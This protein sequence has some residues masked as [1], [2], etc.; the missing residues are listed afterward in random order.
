MF[1]L[2]CIF[3]AILLLI[4]PIRLLEELPIGLVAWETAAITLVL[5]V[6]AQQE[7]RARGQN[8][9]TS[10]AP[11]VQ[12]WVF[13]RYGIG[14]L[15]IYYWDQ[16]EWIVPGLERRYHV[17]PG[18]EHLLGACMI[19]VLGALGIY[20][21]FRVKVSGLARMLP[22]VSW[23]VDLEKLQRNALLYAPFGLFVL[24]YL[25]PRLPISIRFMVSLFATLTYALIVMISYWWFSARRGHR[26]QWAI[27]TIAICGVASML[28]L[29]SGQ[30]G[31]VFVPFMMVFLGYTAARGRVPWRVLVP[32][33]LIAF[34][35]VAPF[36]TVYKYSK[37][38]MGIENP[39]VEDRINFTLE[40]LEA[41]SYEAGVELAVDRFVGR[42]VLIEFPAVFSAYY[43][44][45]Y[46]Y[47]NGHSFM[48]E[49]S[50][51][52]PR[53][54]WP[55]KPQLSVELNTY[56]QKVGFIQEGDE[57]SAVFDAFAEYYVNFG[58]LGVFLLGGVHAMYLKVLYEWLMRSLDV[59]SAVS[60]HLMVFL[61]NFDFF[62]VGQM[63]V[64]HIK[65]IPVAIIVFYILGRQSGPERAYY[66]ARY[67]RT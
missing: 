59:L 50:S 19:A 2:C 30:V 57:T 61:L 21:G 3:A 39:S 49:L 35:A 62:G 28:G 27:S 52:V 44:N 46:E 15:L 31:Q 20:C 66:G 48:V 60:I 41:M 33:G 5:F 40:S 32:I 10:V 56:S 1:L 6:K 38:S 53:F 34:F 43:P 64:S 11:L 29:L 7:A 25:N 45:S 9:W 12:G 4:S 18:R 47:A 24:L 63:F 58:L 36:L 16:Y 22:E 65:L 17:L 14:A 67:A 8:P 13:V 54:L 23:P 42:M 37:Y 51:L 55:D 26:L